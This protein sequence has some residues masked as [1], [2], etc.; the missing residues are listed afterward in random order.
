MS[1]KSL[2]NVLLA[3]GVLTSL[4]FLTSISAY[5]LPA[6]ERQTGKDCTDCHVT[7]PEL[8]PFGRQFK[9]RGYTLGKQTFPLSGMI[10]ASMTS[11]KNFAGVDSTAYP[12]NNELVLQAV[13]LFYGGKITDHSGA[14]SQWTYDGV[15]HDT[16]IDNT[17]IRYANTTL[18]N[19]KELIYGLTL[20][21][22]P[23][24]QDI[25]NST[26]AWR[27]PFASSSVAITPAASPLIEGG[28]AAQVAGL[29]VYTFWNNNVY[30]ELSAYHTANGALSVFRTGTDATAGGRN[31]LKGLAPYWRLA[32][33]N[34]WDN[35][36][37]SL[38]LGTFGLIADKYPDNTNPTGPTDR[39]KDIGVDAQYQFITDAHRF[40][41][42]TSFIHEKQD[43]NATF[44][45]GGAA[46][47]SDV[48]KTFNAKLMYYYQRKYGT[49]LAYFSTTGDTDAGLYAPAAVTGSSSGS[50]NSRGYIMELNYLPELPWG[51]IRLTLQYTAYQKF[52]GASTNYDGAG[53]NASDNNTLYLNAWFMF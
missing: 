30:A 13:S 33:E 6:F 41:A 43:W 51:D 40:S 25:W 2:I 53:R 19:G 28:L 16:Q 18:V 52:N 29:G 21:N 7:F 14:F 46:H 36:T 22:N 35:H 17:D 32:V 3:T 4:F 42:Q 12:K 34:D 47:P 10:Q 49:A 37:H 48:L 8:T 24:V 5:A 9:L 26:P 44:P 23:T 27:F 1:K 31:E 38:M 20:N 50:P 11:T 45:A 39:F 15:T